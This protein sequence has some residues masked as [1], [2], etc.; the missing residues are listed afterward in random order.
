MF[1]VVHFYGDFYVVWQWTF[2]DSFAR[3]AWFRV[4]VG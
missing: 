3:D 2:W 1:N 4:C